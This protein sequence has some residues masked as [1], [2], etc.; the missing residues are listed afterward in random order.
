MAAVPAPTGA[1]GVAGAGTA[2]R[3]SHWSTR[4]ACRDVDPELFFD[5]SDRAEALHI[6][7]THCDVQKQ[8]RAHA[9]QLNPPPFDCVVGGLA[10]GAH[11]LRAGQPEPAKRCFLCRWRP[12]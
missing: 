4:A 10:W 8:C 6:C 9:E 3:D 2:H 11:R 12:T 1:A 7:V 5:G